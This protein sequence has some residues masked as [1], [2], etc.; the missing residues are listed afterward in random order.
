MKIILSTVVALFLLGCGESKSTSHEVKNEAAVK[1]EVVEKVAVVEEKVAPKEEKIVVAEEKV[2]PTETKE[3]VVEEVVPEAKEA[4]SNATSSID[5]AKLYVACAGCHGVHGEKKA[6]GKSQVIGG[7]E[8]SKVVTA[9]K[10]YQD[11][12]YG[13]AMKAVMKGQASKLTPQEITA[14]SEYISALK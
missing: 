13:G 5:A 7:W 10:G 3:A 6:L 1:S 14:L 8:A 9:L 4:A 2:T 12:T 11:G